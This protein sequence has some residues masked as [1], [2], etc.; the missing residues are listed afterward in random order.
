[1]VKDLV[2]DLLVI[3]HVD[4][5]ILE[6]SI[7]DLHV[8]EQTV[9]CIKFVEKFELVANG[10]TV[11]WYI[12]PVFITLACARQTDDA[13]ARLY[14]V[15]A[16]W[17]VTDSGKE[18]TVFEFGYTHVHSYRQKHLCWLDILRQKKT[19]SENAQRPQVDNL[20]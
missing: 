2:A 20:P 16:G 19:S 11:A 13:L 8:I 3:L 6:H 10:L 9:L 15:H 12:S 17:P 4:T 14:Q 5:T 18:L 7:L 1:M